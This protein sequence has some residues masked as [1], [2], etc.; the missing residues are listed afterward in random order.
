MQHQREIVWTFFISIHK[1]QFCLK[2]HLLP[3][4]LCYIDKNINI[5]KN[6]SRI[7]GTY[8]LTLALK[9]WV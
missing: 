7:N 1:T 9:S 6:V 5:T 8:L 4:C 3:T 2:Q